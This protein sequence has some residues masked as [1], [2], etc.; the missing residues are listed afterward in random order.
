MLSRHNRQYWRNLPYVGLG[1]GAHGYFRG[2]GMQM[3]SV[4]QI[5]SGRWG[6]KRGSEFSGVVAEQNDV[7]R[8]QEMGETMMMGLR[9]LQEG[10]SAE[11]FRFRFGERNWWMSMEKRSARLL[12]FGLLEWAGERSETLRLTERGY[13]LG[14]QVFSAVV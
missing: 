11:M 14:N 12:G 7:D 8:A 1:A 2:C 6:K 13:L 3:S 10:V 9:L 5:T 4:W